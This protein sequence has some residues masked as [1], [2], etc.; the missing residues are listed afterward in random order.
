MIST[1]TRQASQDN[2]A[3]AAGISSK[4]LKVQIFLFFL[5]SLFPTI[6]SY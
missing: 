6:M 2:G 5:F 4:T 1:S 3:A